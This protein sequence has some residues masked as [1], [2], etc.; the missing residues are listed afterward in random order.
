MKLSLTL[1]LITF[2]FFTQAQ[3]NITFLN[4]NG[5]VTKE[6]SATTLLQ[7]TR[8]SDTLWEVNVYAKAGPRTVSKQC[9]DENCTV[10]N[11]RYISYNAAGGC[12]SMGLYHNGIREGRWSVYASNGRLVWEL[13]YSSGQLTSRR[14]S[15]EIRAS[16]KRAQ[17]SLSGGRT[18]VDEEASFPGGSR[19]WFQYLAHAMRY[20]DRAVNYEISGTPVVGFVVAADGHIEKD[21]IQIFRSVE[22]SLDQLS[23]K[24]IHESPDWVP[25]SHDGRK[26]RS[27]MKQ[28][29][30]FKLEVN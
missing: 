4:E 24:I 22:Y 26:V 5:K 29:L 9:R 14:D 25:A 2:T 23:I 3:E 16:G 20:P 6:K 13:Q 30:Q 7:Q 28:P 12:D 11:G 15:A 8:L 10:L 17:D 27:Y 19:G 18:V 21:S 1:I